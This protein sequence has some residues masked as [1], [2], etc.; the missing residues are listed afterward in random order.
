MTYGEGDAAADVRPLQV[1][2]G[3]GGTDDGAPP[4]SSS[5]DNLAAATA[6]SAGLR[7][8]SNFL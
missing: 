5:S 8:C 1:L 4:S 2:I 7:N 6:V 3:D